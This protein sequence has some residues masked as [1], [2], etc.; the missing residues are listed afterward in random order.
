MVIPNAAAIFREW[1][2]EALRRSLAGQM[3]AE[4]H[5]SVWP[6]RPVLG[7]SA[8]AMERCP[9]EDQRTVKA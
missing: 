3:P 9:R 1:P 5:P 2:S 4:R 7:S 6:L 8:C